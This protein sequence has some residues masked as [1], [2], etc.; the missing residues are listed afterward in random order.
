MMNKITTSLMAIV[1]KIKG[2]L[3]IL[4]TMSIKLLVI[5][6]IINVKLY[7]IHLRISKIENLQNIEK[8]LVQNHFSA[9]A[10]N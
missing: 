7:N 1:N 10:N 8:K 6:F 2:Y 4:F 5:L 9:P 3:L